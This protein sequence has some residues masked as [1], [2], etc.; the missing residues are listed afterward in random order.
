MYIPVVSKLGPRG[1]VS[2]RFE[3][4]PQLST[5]KPA[6]QAL[7]KLELNSAGHQ[8]SRTKFGHPWY[9]YI[10][11]CIILANNHRASYKS[12]KANHKN[13]SR[14]PLF[15]INF[16][17]LFFGLNN[18]SGLFCQTCSH[19]FWNIS[20]SFWVIIFHC[21]LHSTIRSVLGTSFM[22]TISSAQYIE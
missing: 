3:R 17:Y 18:K 19:R 15:Y 7:T 6:N 11:T 20:F 14:L 9:I 5:P 22:F 2:C 1:L 10:Y 13:F 4:Q 16:F 21:L 8:P 12:V